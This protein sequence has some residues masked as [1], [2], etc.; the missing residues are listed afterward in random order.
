MAQKLKNEAFGLGRHGPI[1]TVSLGG[2]SGHPFPD[3]AFS[4]AFALFGASE[5]VTQSARMRPR[6]I[7]AAISVAVVWGLSFIAIKVG[8]GETS[9]LMLAA[10]RFLFAALPCV[11]FIAP[12]AAPAWTVVLYGLLIG[13]GQFGVLFIAIHQ[14]FPV[15]LSSLVIQAQVYFTIL[16]AWA[17]LGERPRRAQ[18]IGAAVAFL[19]IAI[20]GSERLAGA[21]L[22]P[23]LLVVLAAVFWGSGNALAKTVGKVDM[24]A[25]TV[26]SSLAAPL[27]LILLS[28]AVEGKGGLAALAHPGWRLV[29]SVLVLS[30]AG[31][32]FGYGL[33]ARLLAEYSAATVG[34]FALLV[35]VVGMVAAAILFGEPL[36]PV[37]LFGG[38]L[39][40]A[41]LALNVAGDW[42]TRRRLPGL[43]S[44]HARYQGDP[45]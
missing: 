5:F 26:W 44:E 6:D 7:L 25:F 2:V 24:L 31:T 13:V 17:F 22:G 32:V 43:G 8:V 33:W 12:P 39:V 15:G 38:V 9:P 41:G 16:L 11:F 21:S 34:P 29:V 30:Y 10:L 40:M 27:P 28:L 37:E 3:V 45:R 36:R 14:G 19:G 1:L 4:A 42:M 23:F 20:I 35:P 18:I